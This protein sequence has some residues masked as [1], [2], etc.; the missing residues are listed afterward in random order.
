MSNQYRPEIDGLRALAILPIL[1][2]HLR[3]PMGDYVALPGGFLGVDVFFVISG[4]LITR[5]IID[6]FDRTQSFS[7]QNFYIRRIR[8]ILPPL[9]LVVLASI[10]AAY[11][12]LLP[13]EMYRFASSLVAALGFFSNFFWSI[14][15]GQ[16]GAQSAALQPFLHTWS[17]AI[18]EQF[19][20]FFPLL[21]LFFMKRSTSRFLLGVLIFLIGLSFAA[22]VWTTI[23]AQDMSFFSPISRAWELLFGG[24][25]AYVGLRWPG[26]LRGRQSITRFIPT[27]ALLA[28]SLSFVFLRVTGP[29]HPGAWTLIV[30]LATAALIWFADPKEWVTRLFSSAPMVFIGKQSYS[31]Y[32]WHFPI[33]AF[34][35]LLSIDAPDAFDMTAWLALTFALSW[36]GYHLVERPFRFKASGLTL[37]LSIGGSLAL[38]AGFV[39]IW[40]YTSLIQ[41]PRAAY[42]KM[43]YGPVQ[44]N[45]QVLGNATYK[46]L[47][48]LSTDEKIGAWNAN[49]PS[50][51]ELERLWFQDPNRTNVLV[52]GN[53]HAKDFFN[54]VHVSESHFQGPEFARFAMNG[55]MTPEARANLYASPNFEAA[56]IVVLAGRYYDH[57]YRTI[58]PEMLKELTGVGK[59]VVLV[60][61]TPEFQSPGGTL[62]FFDWYVRRQGGVDAVALNAAAFDALDVAVL[63]RNEGLQRIAEEHGVSYRSRQDLLCNGDAGSCMLVTPDGQKMMYDYGHWTLDGAAYLGKKMAGEGWC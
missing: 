5:I 58:I 37:S 34:G 19:Y 28:I 57:N 29:Q 47:A 10:P 27:I 7:I 55:E 3:I 40:S 21:L 15:L 14:E 9:I 24:L 60:G 56:D 39:V 63:E 4:F 49:D 6:E 1:V 16:Y 23:V 53:S 46:P 25:M 42:M 13:T 35:R 20:I 18:E 31:I 26:A 22:A 51:N 44:Y 43:L 38:V 50:I 59:K 54:A 48:A 52:V 41:S 17:L 45:N 32:L 62:P 12:I 30:V 8:R 11:F 36:I 61:N 2:Y 33:F